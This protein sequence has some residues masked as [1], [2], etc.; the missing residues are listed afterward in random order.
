MK[1]LIFYTSLFLSIIL[2][3]TKIYSQENTYNILNYDIIIEPDFVTKTLSLEAK[4]KI[5]N[6]GLEH[7]FTFGLND[8]YTKIE[9]TSGNSAVTYK[10][11]DGRTTVNVLNPSEKLELKFQL[12]GKPGKSI[13][14]N[15]EVIEKESLFLLWSD[16]F[17]PIDFGDWA[18]VKTTV[19]L[20]ENFQAIAS[21]RLISTIRK[22]KKIKYVFESSV[23]NANYSVFADTRWIK[24]EREINGIKMQTLLFPES[25]KYSEQIFSTSSEVLQFFSETLCPYPFDQFSFITISGMYARRAFAGFVGYTPAYLEKEFTTTGHDAHETSLLWW[26]HIIAGRGSGSW[27][28]LEGFGDYSEI[29]YDKKYNKPIPKIFQLFRERYLASDFEKDL[30]YSELRGNTRQESIHGKYPWLMHFLRYCLGDE[31]FDKAMLYLFK[32]YKFQTVSIDEFLSALEKG[33]GKPIKWFMEEWLERRGVPVISFKYNVIK[34]ADSYKI[35]C[36]IEQIGNLYHLPLEI[37]IETK[38]GIIVKKVNLEE[39]KMKFD[40]DSAKEPLKVLLDLNDWII[41]KKIVEL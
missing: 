5:D 26:G 41:M 23:P 17:Y 1:K 31:S 34:D 30:L 12:E 38:E 7:E 20:P 24:T 29:Y 15:R 11:D 33:S 40:F 39:K 28:W 18:I 2:A 22:N 25:Q 37:G 10:K 36:E 4:I 21:G 16:R 6:P 35:N 3:Q 14:E 13:D 19:I 27:Q 9:V 32:N 8:N